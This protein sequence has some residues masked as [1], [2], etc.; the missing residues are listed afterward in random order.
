ML[1]RTFHFNT[2]TT[3]PAKNFGLNRKTDIFRDIIVCHVHH[4]SMLTVNLFLH[5]Q[6]KKTLSEGTTVCDHGCLYCVILLRPRKGHRSITRI[7][8]AY[9]SSETITTNPRD[10]HREFGFVV[11]KVT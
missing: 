4:I 1:E 2:E 3:F 10:F 6:N 7:D 5:L 8:A 9:P 11:A